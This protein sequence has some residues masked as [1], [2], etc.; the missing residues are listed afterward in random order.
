MRAKLGDFGFALEL[1]ESC[2]GRTLVTAP[3]IARTDGYYPP[4]IMLGKF[5]GKSDV[6]SYG[7]VSLLHVFLYYYMVKL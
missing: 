6:Y 1:P 7:V 3:L 2:A 5:S 4:E